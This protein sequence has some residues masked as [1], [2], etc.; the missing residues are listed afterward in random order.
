MRKLLSSYMVI[1]PLIM[2]IFGCS[3]ME[4]ADKVVLS[5]EAEQVIFNIEYTETEREIIRDAITK[6]TAFNDK[7]KSVIENPVQLSVLGNARLLSD[8]E[9]IKNTYLAIEHI[10]TLN[11]HR[12]NDET[13]AQ[14]LKYQEMAGDYDRTMGTIKTVN[15]VATYGAIVASIAAKML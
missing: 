6:Y 5:G 10:I 15:D 4:K 9:D 8:Y 13:Q 12:Y 2:L 3:A 14:L 7:W 11:F 1:L